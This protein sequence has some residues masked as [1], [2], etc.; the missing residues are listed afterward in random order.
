M[1]ISMTRQ[2]AYIGAGAGLVLFFLFGLLPG[3]LMG[4]AAGIRFAGVFFGLPLEPGLFSRLIVLCSMLL[5]GLVAGTVIITASS[6]VGWLAGSAMSALM[7]ENT[8]A[9]VERR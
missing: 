2:G 4:G 1:K 9:E 8:L 5:G 7:R 3:S 6:T